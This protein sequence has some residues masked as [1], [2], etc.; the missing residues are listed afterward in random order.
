MLLKKSKFRTLD[1]RWTLWETIEPSEFKGFKTLK[2]RRRK[3][4]RK[5]N[6]LC[7]NTPEFAAKQGI[8][9]CPSKYFVLK[10]ISEK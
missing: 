9:W 7:S 10:W 6:I 1:I 8:I 3:L 5:S 2:K 4:L